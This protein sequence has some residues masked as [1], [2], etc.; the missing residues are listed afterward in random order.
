MVVGVLN[1][2]WRTYSEA[3]GNTFAVLLRSETTVWEPYRAITCAH[4]WAFGMEN[5]LDS[6]SDPGIVV[7]ALSFRYFF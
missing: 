6:L 1:F 7:F 3:N 5:V 2:S 4:T